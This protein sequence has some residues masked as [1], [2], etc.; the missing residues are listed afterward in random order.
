MDEIRK[1]A[2]RAAGLTRQL[3]M[4][5]RQQV[6]EPKVLDL[7]EVL[8]GMDKMLQRILGEDVELVSLP[9][10]SIGRVKADPSHIEQV[11][12]NL[13]VNARDAM[14]TGGKLTIETGNVV[15]DE[16]LRPR[17]ICPRRPAPT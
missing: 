11:I 12:L 1:A 8:T 2:L 17:A 9:P 3:L 14:P 16:D 15:L 6:V 5:S 13:V 4:F 10:K 7:H